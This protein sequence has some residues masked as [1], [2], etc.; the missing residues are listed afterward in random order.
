M[1][2][3]IINS[4]SAQVQ[5]AWKEKLLNIL[6]ETIKYLEEEELIVG[7]TYLCETNDGL[8]LSLTYV[9]AG[10]FAGYLHLGSEIRY[11][12]KEI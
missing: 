9:G 12:I 5:N 10:E 2:K 3:Q 4:K 6:G 11:A 7:K 1:T 8:E